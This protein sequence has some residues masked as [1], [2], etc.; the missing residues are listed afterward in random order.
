MGKYTPAP[1]DHVYQSH[2][3]GPPL[4]KKQNFAYFTVFNSEG[5]YRMQ[6]DFSPLFENEMDTMALYNKIG[7]MF[8]DIIYLQLQETRAIERLGLMPDQHGLLPCMFNSTRD[9]R[10]LAIVEVL[11]NLEHIKCEMVSNSFLCF[12]ILN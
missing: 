3:L 5:R 4:W 7:S 11:K 1:G 8:C 2:G 10:C 6:R 9:N 12:R